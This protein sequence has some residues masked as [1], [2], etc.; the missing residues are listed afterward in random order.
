MNRV[1]VTPPKR[2]RRP[3]IGEWAVNPTTLARYRQHVVAFIQ[4]QW[5]NDESARDESEMDEILLM[6]IHDLY[7]ERGHSGKAVAVNTIYGIY[8]YLPDY[9]GCLPRSQQAIKGWNRHVIGRSAPPLTWEL[10]SALAVQLARKPQYRRHAVAVMLGFDCLLRI[11]EVLGL[12]REDV[13]DSDD[14]RL[15]AEKTGP[16]TIIRIR[17]AKTGKNQWVVIHDPQVRSMVLHLVSVTKKGA[18]LFPISTSSFRAVFHR[19]CSELRFELVVC[20]AFTTSWWSDSISSHAPLVYGGCCRTWSLGELQV[21]EDI[22]SSWNCFTH[23]DDC[24]CW[25][26]GFGVQAIATSSSTYPGVHGRYFAKYYYYAIA[27]A[28]VTW[29]LGFV[30]PSH[31]RIL[32]LRCSRVSSPVRVPKSNTS[33]SSTTAVMPRGDENGQLSN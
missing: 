24:T 26:G 30:Y 1:A 12:R 9:K 15:G 28:R 18:L 4:W 23:V 32:Q 6:Y 27:E 17:K 13:A 2:H 29:W 3:F 19:G 14:P 10:A 11:G 20:P 5:Q 22:H 21:S 33:L 7:E 8:L 31:I 25:V 16:G